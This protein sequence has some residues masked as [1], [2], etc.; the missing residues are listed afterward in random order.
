MN[1]SINERVAHEFFDSGEIIVID[2]ERLVYIIRFDKIATPRS[3]GYQIA[4]T[5]V[6]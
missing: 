5:K 2:E 1:F 3:I 4:L 6:S